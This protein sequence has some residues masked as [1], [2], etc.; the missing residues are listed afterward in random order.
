MNRRRFLF[1]YLNN[2]HLY[3]KTAMNRESLAF[4]FIVMSYGLVHADDLDPMVI[5]AAKNDQVILE[6][7]RNQSR[8]LTDFFQFEPGVLV[9]K[10]GPAQGSPYIRG[11]TGQHVMMLHDGFKL[12]SSI[13]RSGPNQYWNTINSATIE[14]IELT[15]GS[16]SS[17]YG[18]GAVA[19]VEALS[20]NQMARELDTRVAAADESVMG[21]L[22]YDFSVGK[23]TVTLDG[24]ANRFGDMKVADLGTLTGTGYDEY[25]GGVK[26]TRTLGEGL[27]TLSNQTFS[28]NNA[29]RWHSTADNNHSWEGTNLGNHLT[30]DFYQ[31]R[32]FSYIRYDDNRFFIGYTRQKQEEIENNMRST[33]DIRLSGFT[34]DTDGLI[35]QWTIRPKT[36]LGYE[37][38]L[39]HVDS[40]YIR[41]GTARSD[42]PVGNNSTYLDSGIYADHSLQ[43]GATEVNLGARFSQARAKVSEYLNSNSGQVESLNK[44]WSNLSMGISAHKDLGN[45]RLFGGINQGFRAPNLSDLTK[46]GTARSGVQSQPAP[47][48][49]DEKFISCDLGFRVGSNQHHL[50]VDLYHTTIRDTISEMMISGNTFKINSGKA[51][52]QGLDVVWNNHCGALISKTYLSYQVGEDEYLNDYLSRTNPLTLGQNLSVAGDGP[53]KGSLNAKWVAKADKLSA[54]DIGDTQRIPPGGT[55]AYFLFNIEV[56]YQF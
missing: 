36:H 4:F 30:R 12:N 6:T 28:Q 5:T 40:F 53:W 20:R 16:A 9:Q 15:K 46:Y 47:D 54:G 2:L 42:T 26:I 33:T 44:D 41:N 11:F 56:G 19:A 3:P 55:P 45:L 18:S 31:K 21:T 39:D 13:L 17:R 14:R 23:T 50:E 8:N 27:L 1:V 35:G 32:V 38:Y 49:D 51:Y 37:I 24:T 43:W 7:A 34:V 10:T 25:G 52:V 22:K 29:S 48:L